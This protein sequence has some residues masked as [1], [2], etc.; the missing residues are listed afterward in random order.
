MRCGRIIVRGIVQ[1]VGF[2]PFVYAAAVR[3]GIAGSVI[4]HGS[5]V[6]ITACGD[7]FDEFCREVSK[8]PKMSVIDSVTV[9]PLSEGD[10]DTSGFFIL[11]SADGARTGFIPADIA[12]CD[13]CLADI[14]DP[15]SRYYGYW[16]TSCTDCGPRYSIIRAV[17]Y[18][19]ERTSMEAFS[20]C[21]DCLT[22]YQSPENRRHHAQTIAC[23]DCGPKLSLL[24][25]SGEPVVTDDPIKTT[26]ELLDAGYIVAVRGVGGYHIC[27]IEEQAGRLKRL[28]GRPHQSLA[29]MMQPES[30]AEYVV[31]LTDA[32]REMLTGPVH[33]I[34]ILDKVDPEAHRELSELHNLGVM[35]PYTGLHHLLFT[36]LQH[37]LL[38]MTSAN[39]PGT[40]MITKT[41]YIS[42][43]MG[44]VAEYILSHDREI[45]NRCDDSV[46][47]DGYIIRLSRGL[48]PLR[49]AM[50]LGDRQI[51]GVGPELNANATIYK[52]GFVVTSPHIGNIRNPPTVAYL[53]ETIEKLTSLTGAKP[54][55]IAH[56]LHPQFLSTR[57][58]HTLAE[59][60][61]AVLCPVQHHRAHIASVTTEEVVGI[62][63]DGVGYGDDATIW[64]GEI[65]TGSPGEG[66]TR[67][68]H[69]E[70]VLM[71]GGDLATKFPE[72][73]LYGILPDAETLSL[74]S[75][76]GWDDTSLRVLEQQT[77]KRFNCPATT[78]TGRVLDAAAALLGICRERT[79][80]GEPS[81]VLEAYAAR[82][83]PQPLEVRIVSG[84]N[85]ADVL[86]TSEILREGR[87]MIKRGVSV[88]Y[89]AA[90]MQTA[91]AKGI[92][93]L[94]LRSAEKT[95]ISTAALS[96]GVAI[97]RSIRETILAEL[98]DAGVRCLTNPRY[99]FG[100]GCISC[101]QVITAGILAK[102]G[103]L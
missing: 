31:P 84:R 23:R 45:V 93:E 55:I 89:T 19:R 90:T 74:L 1:G 36:H 28:L 99:P 61:G 81:M 54:G 95:G 57:L 14:M 76:R 80:D 37:P 75:E 88:P 25:S 71:P 8:G 44:D 24:T 98:A 79:Y 56:D 50:D 96:G 46:V 49:T 59:E 11:P 100:D 17:P 41:S 101:G 70:Q 77:E 33:P 22:E 39:A 103:K 92:A 62:A 3:L 64:G 21:N 43:R 6:E 34:M 40:P 18:D 47:R 72:R 27:C 78:S 102:E 42:E 67:T 15:S 66:Y 87:A 2:R 97:N 32:E 52:G 94:A 12:T 58:A 20:P 65:L 35:L 69:L 86:L 53:E 13:A 63:I 5:E 60:W 83:T 4:N 26:A 68:G 48:A 82:G 91:L 7:R 29:V 38:V 16:A 30:L 85:G 51:L 10:V 9:E 73:M